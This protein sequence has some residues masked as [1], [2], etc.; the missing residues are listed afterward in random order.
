MKHLSWAFKRKYKSD[1][2]KGKGE[3][4]GQA[5]LEVWTSVLLSLV[6]I[7]RSVLGPLRIKMTTGQVLTLLVLNAI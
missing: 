6:L 3:H 2:G 4:S 7:I 5:N 1:E